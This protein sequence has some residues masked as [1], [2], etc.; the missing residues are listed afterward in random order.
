M[1]AYSVPETRPGVLAVPGGAAVEAA[2]S[3]AALMLAQGRTSQLVVHR[4]TRARGYVYAG[5]WVADCTRDGC[6]GTEFI[7]RKPRRLRGV[8]GTRGPRIPVLVCSHC[9]M[10]ALVEWPREWLPITEVLE[11]RPIPHT[12][13]WYPAGHATAVVNGVRDGETV[14][15]LLAENHEHGVY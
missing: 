5:E 2:R 7:T 4:S 14:A 9:G 8:A 13:N 11:R 6:G 12:R 3:A 15:E 1:T 10:R